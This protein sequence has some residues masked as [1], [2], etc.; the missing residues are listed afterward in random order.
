MLARALTHATGHLPRLR[1]RRRADADA[2]PTP[3]CAR[4]SSTRRRPGS[5]AQSRRR[6]A[7]RG[8][9][10]CA[11][12][13]PSTPGIVLGTLDRAL[14]RAGPT[15][16]PSPTPATHA[17]RRRAGQVLAGTLALAGITAENMVR[18]PGWHFLDAGRRIERALQLPSLLRWTVVGDGTAAAIEQHLRRVGAHR[19]REHRHLPPPLPGAGPARDRCSTCC[20]STRSNPRSLAFQLDRAGADLAHAARRRAW[21][22]G[23]SP[24]LDDAEAD[25]GRP[26]SPSRSPR[27]HRRRPP[28]PSELFADAPR[29]ARRSGRRRARPAGCAAAADASSDAW[30]CRTIAPRPL[31]PARSRVPARLR[32]LDE[33]ALPGHPPHEYTYDDDVTASYGMVAPAA[34]RRAEP[35]VPS[36]TSSTDPVPRDLQQPRRLLRQ[37]RGVLPVTEPHRRS[38]SPPPASSTC[39]P[40]TPPLGP[41]RRAWEDVRAGLPRRTARGRPRRRA[42]PPRLAAAST[43]APSVARV[44]RGRRS[45]PGRPLVEAVDRPD[46]AH[47]RRLRLRRPA[48]PTSPPASPRCCELRGAGSARTSPTWPSPACAASGS[49]PA[50]SAATSRP[51]RRPGRPALVGADASHAWA[52]SA[53]PAPAGC[54]RR[55]HQRPRRPATAHH[56]RPGVAT[57][58]T[59]RRSRASSSPRRASRR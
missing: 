27:S 14:A 51:S 42:V 12:S 18:D 23:C 44:R 19:R 52:R 8:A 13:C 56:H 57:T 9:G 55:P 47:P 31:G 39:R 15:A 7:R 11:T 35:A 43:S 46:A 28:R 33:P 45:P 54:R 1:R 38:W 22:G 6:H 3:S 26:R 17:A 32:R 4:C 50:T 40:R 30:F 48:P 21:R 10:R 2:A 5:L 29:R 16:A 59:C 41:G 25:L 24:A 34:A 20:C 37:P 58:A 53:C 49:P 36:S